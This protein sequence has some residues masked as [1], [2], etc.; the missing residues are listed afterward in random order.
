MSSMKKTVTVSSSSSSRGGGLALSGLNLG[1]SRGMTAGSTYSRSASHPRQFSSYSLTTGSSRSGPR[2]SLAAGAGTLGFSR[3]YGSSISSG[4]GSSS[5]ALISGGLGMNEKDTMQ[6]L[7]QRLCTYLEKVR[8]LE[9]DNCRLEKEIREFATSRSID[10]FDWSVYNSTVKPLQEQI[11]NA[12]LQNSQVCLEI[13][14]AKLAAEDFKNK[15]ETELRLRQSVELDIDGLHQLKQTYLDLQGNLVGEIAALEED[16][17]ALKKDHEEQLRMLRQQKTSDIDV[18]VDT[19]PSVDLAAKLQEMRDSYAM[20]ADQNKKDLDNWYQEQVQIQ[21]TQTTQANLASDGVKAELTKYHQDLQTL[22]AEYNALLGALRG[23]ENNLMSVESRYSMELQ[24]VQC[25]IADLEGR[26]GEIR[27]S[28]C[29]QTQEYEKLLNIK[30]KL[31]SEIQQYRALLNQS[32]S[33][34]QSGGGS[35]VSFG[36]VSGS[37]S[38]SGSVSQS[39]TGSSTSTTTTKITTERI[40]RY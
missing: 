39:G 28:I 18:Q 31:E 38:G 21:V 40:S 17:A 20:I 15:L 23:L 29:M 1:G 6:A 11:I 16:I 22:N 34:I 10:T 7:N 8:S 26:L 2:I 9:Q 35:S 25:R 19:G 30:M 14:N 12:I 13:D 33:T 37:K 24:T 36:L 27:N 5:L 32:Q 3:G 4:L